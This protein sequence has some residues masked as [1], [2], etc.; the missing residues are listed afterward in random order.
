MLCLSKCSPK[1]YSSPPYYLCC[2]CVCVS[3][4]PVR[5]RYARLCE[6]EK[7]CFFYTKACGVTQ[8]AP[9]SIHSIDG[10]VMFLECHVLLFRKA[11]VEHNQ[12]IEAIYQSTQKHFRVQPEV[13]DQQD[14]RALG[15]APQSLH[16]RAG[17]PR[18]PG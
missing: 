10:V 16:V 2:L 3:E 18:G 17:G 1:L 11:L 14:V 6:W 9:S 13:L 12:H 5:P 15:A 7:A 8:Q 4:C